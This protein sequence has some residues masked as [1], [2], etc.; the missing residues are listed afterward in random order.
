MEKKIHIY[1]DGICNLCAGAMEGISDSAQK[2]RFEMHDVTAGSL[3]P[4]VTYDAAMKNMHIQDEQ[5]RVFEGAQAVLKIIEQYPAWRWLARLGQL[6]GF[7]LIAAGIYR[8][9]AET[10]YY[11]F[12]RRK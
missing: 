10:R 4:N 3:P 1:Y 11:F 12:G 2:S 7:S 9:V 6:P 8:I 5:G